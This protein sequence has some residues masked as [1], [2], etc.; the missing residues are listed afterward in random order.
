AGVSEIVLCTPPDTSG[1]PAQATLAAAALAG[2]D[3]I[4]AVGGAGAIAGMALGTETIPRVDRVVG[5]GNA[6][7]AAA[8]LQLVGEVG[9]DSP[10]GPSELLVI[11]DASSDPAVVAG[12]MVA[13]AEHDPWACVVAAVVG[14]AMAEAI[15]YEVARQ[16]A[17]APRRDIVQRA[18]AAQGGIV[19]F[20]RME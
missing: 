15:E 6:Y 10:A 1:R 5:P 18:L 20:D 13:Q 2:V 4:F 7:V 17:A 14:G 3:R 12:E 8:K 16:S 19:R 11:A 9:I